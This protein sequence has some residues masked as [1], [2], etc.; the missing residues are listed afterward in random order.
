M[1]CDLVLPGYAKIDPSLTNEGRD[2]SSGQ[3]DEGEREVLDKGDVEARVTVELDV[4]T[5]QQIQTSLV[6]AALWDPS[7]LGWPCSVVHGKH[8]L[9]HGEQ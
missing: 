3:K 6:E 8:T 4:G 1:L 5:V 9:G 2:V 7:A